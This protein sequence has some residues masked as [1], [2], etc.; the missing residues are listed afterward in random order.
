MKKINLKSVQDYLSRDEM[1]QV[2][3]GSGSA[4]CRCLNGSDTGASHPDCSFCK[5]R[6]Y[7]GAFICT[8]G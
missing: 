3:G 5:Q 6:C 1:R 2:S 8:G 4:Y 7:G